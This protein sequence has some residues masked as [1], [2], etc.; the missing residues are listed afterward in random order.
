MTDLAA[1]RQ[2]IEDRSVPEPNSGCHL[3]MGGVSPG[4]YGK[5]ALNRR[6]WVAHRLSWYAATGEHPGEL[7]VCHKCDTPACVNPDHLFL[8]TPAENSADM[9]EKG[10]STWGSRNGRAKLDPDKVRA[11]RAS[12]KRHADISAE[13]GISMALVSLVRN[14]KVWA[15]LD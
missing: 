2:Y 14:R 9:T 4:G 3:W 10:R 12:T 7:F 13:F 6:T 15:F 5:A 11:I 1:V 8:G